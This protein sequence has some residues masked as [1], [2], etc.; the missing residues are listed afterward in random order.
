[1]VSQALRGLSVSDTVTIGFLTP[2]VTALVGYLI[3]GEN[4]SFKECISGLVSL[5]GVILISRPPFIFGHGWGGHPPLPMEPDAYARVR[6]LAFP[7]EEDDS[8]R[9]IGVTWALTGVFFSASAYL[10][11]R[12]I[13]KRANAMHSISYFSMACTIVSGM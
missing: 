6:P 13:G 11:I 12:Y 9:I 5:F 8:A 3:L 7:D 4:F 1:V 2:S 10:S